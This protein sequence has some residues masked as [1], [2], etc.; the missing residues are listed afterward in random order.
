[1]TDAIKA[2]VDETLNVVSKAST[3]PWF[4]NRHTGQIT[5]SRADQALKCAQAVAADGPGK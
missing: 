2:P 5:A 4:N 3:R 1:M